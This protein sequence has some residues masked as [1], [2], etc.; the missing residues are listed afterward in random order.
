MIATRSV[1]ILALSVL[2]VVG[3]CAPGPAPSDAPPATEGAVGPSASFRAGKPM[4]LLIDG[5]P[6]TCVGVHRTHQ[7]DLETE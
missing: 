5:P 7:V 2:A 1:W 3:G 6:V 4:P